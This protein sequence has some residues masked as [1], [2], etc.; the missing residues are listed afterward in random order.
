MSKKNNRVSVNSLEKHYKNNTPE[1]KTLHIPIGDESIEYEVKFRLSLKETLQF[2]EDVVSEYT[3]A[4]DSM[5]VPIVRTYIVGKCIM[6]YYGNFT[7]PQ[8]GEKEFDFI[9]AS[10]SVIQEIT[11][12][13]DQ[14]QFAMIQNAIHERLE[15]EKQKIV[16]SETSRVK[17]LT[18]EVSAL[19]DK[20]SGLFD[21]IDGDQ[22]SQFVTGMTHLAQDNDVT[23]QDIARALVDKAVTINT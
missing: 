13:I 5:I 14:G 17:A 20:M 10:G 8:D 23:S 19:M 2:I 1:T 16:A 9:M 7:M 15:F 22:M 6:T 3:M 18:Y 4:D 11:M 21:G 12:N